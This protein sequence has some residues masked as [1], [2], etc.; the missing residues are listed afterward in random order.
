MKLITLL[1]LFLHCNVFA[2]GVLLNTGDSYVFAFDSLN[3][4]GTRSDLDVMEQGRVVVRFAPYSL[5]DGDSVS[6]EL[7]PNALSDTPLRFVFAEIDF[8]GPGKPS[9]ACEFEGPL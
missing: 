2:Q 8:D 1:I 4:L 3:F 5:S 7:F 6:V 9:L